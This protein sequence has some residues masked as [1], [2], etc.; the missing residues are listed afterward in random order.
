MSQDI[1]KFAVNKAMDSEIFEARIQQLLFKLRNDYKVSNIPV[2]TFARLR[3]AP[4]SD[5]SLLH[6]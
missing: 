3:S 6:R 1:Q 4:D 2:E 5:T